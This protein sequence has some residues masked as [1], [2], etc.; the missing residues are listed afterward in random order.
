[1]GSQLK[2]SPTPREKLRK[3]S[4]KATAQVMP[5]DDP[6][7]TPLPLDVANRSGAG[8][9]GSIAVWEWGK[10]EGNGWRTD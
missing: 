5:P 6:H 10:G 7:K 1:M 8:R 9:L 4:A 2:A 3:R